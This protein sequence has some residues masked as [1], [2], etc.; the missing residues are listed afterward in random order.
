[1]FHSKFSSVVKS[2]D[3]MIHSR[4]TNS[5]EYVNT[6]FCFRNHCCKI[7]KMFLKLEVT[8]QMID[9]IPH[10][11]LNPAWTYNWPTR[12]CLNYKNQ[13]IY[14]DKNALIMKFQFWKLLWNS[15][16]NFLYWIAFS[17]INSL[18]PKIDE[19]RYIVNRETYFVKWIRGR[20]L[21]FSKTWSVKEGRRCCLLN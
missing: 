12:S 3:Q 9:T 1:M 18:V 17:L 7:W 4:I 8:F 13:N 6:N 2:D 21:W 15:W 20:L 14:R 16:S 5:L 11:P 19:V 10:W